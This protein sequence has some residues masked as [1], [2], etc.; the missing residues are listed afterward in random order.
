[1]QSKLTQH[2]CD[3]CFQS[4]TTQAELF[5]H[6]RTCT[7]DPKLTC[8]NCSKTFSRADNL[9]RHQISCKAPCP[10]VCKHA[11]CKRVFQ[12]QAAMERHADCCQK[13]LRPSISTHPGP[14]LCSKPWCSKKFKSETGRKLHE[15]TCLDP[16]AAISL[17]TCSTCK[18]VLSTV[19][20][21]YAHE[22]RCTGLKRAP[23]RTCSKCNVTFANPY[24]TQQHEQSCGTVYECRRKCGAS[25][26]RPF[27][28]ARHE[29]QCSYKAPPVKK[30][31]CPVCVR[32]GFA[33]REEYNAHAQQ[34]KHNPPIYIAMPKEPL[35]PAEKPL[36]LDYNQVAREMRDRNM[37][38][39]P[40]V[41]AF[42]DKT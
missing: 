36:V 31:W 26:G 13:L 38:V 8:R 30:Y 40:C 5:S 2:P 9:R 22:E 21:K 7:V 23:N 14:Y 10:V 27:K 24:Y 34:N 28:R 41:E 37:V 17:R 29:N 3:R 33:T 4:F 32:K 11:W 42:L 1:M 20:A 19:T 12:T 25:F 6:C 15:K 39:P 18:K 35:S 16:A